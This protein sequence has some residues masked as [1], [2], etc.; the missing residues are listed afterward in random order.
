MACQPK[1]VHRLRDFLCQALKTPSLLLLP[2][3]KDSLAYFGLS[4]LIL[5]QYTGLYCIY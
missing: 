4:S 3:K 5:G 2:N 1:K